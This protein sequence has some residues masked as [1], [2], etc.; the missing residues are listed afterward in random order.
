MNELITSMKN[1]KKR[2]H[3]AK[4]FQNVDQAMQQYYFLTGD[5]LPPLSAQP[6]LEDFLDDEQNLALQRGELTLV[7][8]GLII[9]TYL[10]YMFIP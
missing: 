1:L 5:L 3:A 4:A 7:A 10:T 2:V 6:Q 9:T 8:L